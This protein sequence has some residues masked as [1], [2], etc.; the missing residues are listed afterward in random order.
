MQLMVL[1]FLQLIKFH[2]ISPSKM[3]SC[4]LLWLWVIFKSLTISDVN[5]VVV[6]V[7]GVLHCPEDVCFNGRS[8]YV[9]LKE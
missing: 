9:D 1:D 2:L 8:Y 5:L 7:G 3:E 4:E 6:V